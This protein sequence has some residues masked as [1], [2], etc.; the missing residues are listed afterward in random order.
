MRVFGNILLLL[1]VGG[2][3]ALADPVSHSARYR[4]VAEQINIPGVSQVEGEL[5][6]RLEKGCNSWT[7]FVRVDI[8]M[9]G[10][11][12][13]EIHT[14]NISVFQEDLAGRRMQFR[15]QQILNG[16][17]TEEVA[18]TAVTGEIDLTAP[19]QKKIKI[20]KDVIFPVTAM[21]RVLDGLDAGEKF[22]SHKIYDGD[23]EEPYL[24]TEM[25]MKELPEPGSY[26]AGDTGLAE[27][28]PKRMLSSYFKLDGQ[29]QEPFMG[30]EYDL[31]SN[32]V[33]TRVQFDSPEMKLVGTLTHV[34][35]IAKPDC[36]G[37]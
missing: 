9:A 22:L 35:E 2:A 10:Q 36:N 3:S 25:V 32:G 15:T 13:P 20:A 6:S 28:R 16:Q 18:G 4:M 24:V 1:L 12:M 26:P 5:I 11:G 7:Q 14:Q 8:L 30:I 19:E 34:E 17:V 29:D 33:T 21:R 27:G 31:L 23:G 37:T